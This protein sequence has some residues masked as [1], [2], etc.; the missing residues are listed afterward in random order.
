MRRPKHN[1][2]AIML[3]WKHLGKLGIVVTVVT[4]FVVIFLSSNLSSRHTDKVDNPSSINFQR[5]FI[6]LFDKDQ[7]G[8]IIEGEG[9]FRQENSAKYKEK[10]RENVFQHQGQ[11]L[12]KKMGDMSNLNKRSV[13]KKGAEQSGIREKQRDK[14]NDIREKQGDKLNDIRENEIEHKTYI[15]ENQGAQQE[16]VHENQGAQQENVHENQIGQQDDIS[17][18]HEVQQKEI[19]EN[20]IA[21]QKDNSEPQNGQQK[22]T[23]QNQG[24]QQKDIR[25]NQRAQE[26]SGNE[27]QEVLENDVQENQRDTRKKQ[28]PEKGNYDFE[29][30]KHD[31]Y[32][33]IVNKTDILSERGIKGYGDKK[34][35][36]SFNYRY[37][38]S[39]NHTCTQSNT[40]RVLFIV[41]SSPDHNARRV[42]IRETWGNRKRFPLIRTIFSFGIPSNG[43][44]LLNLQ[45]ESDVFRDILLVDYVDNYYNLTLKTINA[46]NWAETY[47]PLAE[48]VLSIDD[49]VYV[50]PDLLINFLNRPNIKKTENVFSGHLLVNTEPIRNSLSKWFVTK[51]EYPFQKYPNYIF[52]GFVIMSMPTVKQ[53][54]KAARYIKL[55]KF[56]DVYLGMLAKVVEIE[57]TNNGYVNSMK[58]FTSSEAFKTLIASHNYYDPKDLQRA[59]D[60]HLSV[61]DQ[62]DDKAVF[63]DFIGDRLRKMQSEINSIMRYMEAVRMKS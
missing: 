12:Y 54:T 2:R 7:R 52:G 49:D 18:N 27:N 55:F 61:L 47:C 42:T 16:N 48:Y 10:S 57:A 21:L 58:T 33:I 35:I 36:N 31:K 9:S 17:E 46:L 34:P 38:I 1:L 43:K 62:D 8:N 5:R 56:E 24:D 25:D 39:P 6:Q 11:S 63:C 20:Q 13:D 23:R 40:P 4:L 15:R 51:T 37:I 29:Y 19:V 44:V 22:D 53:F 32:P 14:L 28:D 60:C 45:E 59:W 26:I 50:A 30:P 3:A 41:K